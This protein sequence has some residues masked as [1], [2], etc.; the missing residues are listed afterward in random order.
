MRKVQ[1]LLSYRRV[2]TTHALY[3]DLYLGVVRQ[4][5]VGSYSPGQSGHCG[6]CVT[7]VLIKLSVE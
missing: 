5:A 6:S 1:D 2:L 4:L 3:I 7:D